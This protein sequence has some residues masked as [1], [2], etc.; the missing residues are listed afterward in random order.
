MADDSPEYIN[1]ER[2]DFVWSI[3]AANLPSQYEGGQKGGIIEMFGWPSTT[4]RRSA[5]SWAAPG[6]L[7]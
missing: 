5:S 3:P 6:D 1:L 7:R 2:L 4:P